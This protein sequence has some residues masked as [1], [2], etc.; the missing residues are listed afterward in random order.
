MRGISTG[1]YFHS[2]CAGMC[3][4]RLHVFGQI[5]LKIGLRA[6]RDA[7]CQSRQLHLSSTVCTHGLGHVHFGTGEIWVDFVGPGQDVLGLLLVTSILCSCGLC[8]V[9]GGL[10]QLRVLDLFTEL[11]QTRICSV[12][13]LLR[14]IGFLAVV[15]IFQSSGL[16]CVAFGTCTFRVDLVHLRHDPHRVFAVGAKLRPARLLG[17]DL[18]SEPCWIDPFAQELRPT[19]I[20]DVS[21]WYWKTRVVLVGLGFLTPG[22]VSVGAQLCSP[23]V[24]GVHL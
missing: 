3:P 7:V 21:V 1:K 13:V 18:A 5:L 10:C 17:L 19:G 2:L 9:G 23:W 4:L 12:G 6:V 16:E 22:L 14:S 15:E 11:G 20:D 24:G 8:A